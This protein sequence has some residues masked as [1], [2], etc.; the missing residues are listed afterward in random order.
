MEPYNPNKPFIS[1]KLDGSLLDRMVEAGIP[2]SRALQYFRDNSEG[3]ALETLKTAAEDIVPFYGNYRNGGGPID[4]LTEAALMFVPSRVP[5][6]SGGR[7]PVNTTKTGKPKIDD[8][9]DWSAYKIDQ[10]RDITGQNIKE[11]IKRLERHR[12]RAK[13]LLNDPD[14]GLS[15]Q[16]IKNIQANILKDDNFINELYLSSLNKDSHAR[17]LGNIPG[18]DRYEASRY[19]YD[20]LVDEY[21]PKEA[22]KLYNKLRSKDFVEPYLSR[23][24]DYNLN[25]NWPEDIGIDK[26]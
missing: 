6:R 18:T 25:L 13:E 26:H 3:S 23:G 4:Y 5:G 24:E 11:R 15:Q 19:I 16:Q 20:K 2:F 14:L 9:K 22:F 8:L 21:G 17:G 1:M 7:R 10:Y 12:D